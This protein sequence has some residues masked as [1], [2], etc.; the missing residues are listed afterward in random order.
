MFESEI[1][2]NELNPPNTR[3]SKLFIEVVKIKGFLS[4][5]RGNNEGC[6]MRGFNL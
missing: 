6:K 1:I 5:R 2:N 4:L 3:T